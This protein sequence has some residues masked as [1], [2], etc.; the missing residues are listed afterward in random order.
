MKK[1][2]HTKKLPPFITAT[3]ALISLFVIFA[4]TYKIAEIILKN[5]GDFPKIE[6]FLKNIPAEQLNTD[7]KDIKYPNNTVTLSL[8]N[9]VTTFENV[10][11]K[12]RGNLT[13]TQAKKPYQIK[14]PEKTQLF[15]HGAARKWLLLA[16]YL[17]STHLRNDVAFYLEHLLQ[18]ETPISGNFLE[19]YIDNIY[20][21]LYYLT[22]KVEI[23]ENRINIKEPSGIIVELD[24]I[25]TTNTDCLAHSFDNDCF[26]IHDIINP[27]L[28][29]ES[30]SDFI[31]KFNQLEI[32]IAQKDFTTITNL[33]D[34]DSFAKYFLL[35]EF[36]NN[37][38][39]YESSFFLSMDGASDL[40]HAGPGWDFDL[41]LGNKIWSI[42]GID[43]EVFLSPNNDL[44]FKSLSLYNSDSTADIKQPK[45]VSSLLYNL[46]EVPEFKTRVKEIY[47]STLSSKKDELLNY[48]KSQA[49]Y[50]RPAAIRDQERWKLKTDW[51]EEVNYL[52]D[53][54][55][56]R[57]NHFEETYN[58]NPTESNF[59]SAP[60][61]D[62][63]PK[64]PQPSEE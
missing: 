9:K 49:D 13:W 1:K 24:N 8:D 25:H 62:P 46:L 41:S 20:Y 10:E 39:G 2:K 28:S 23:E 34:V 26:V 16:N 31:E 17:D 11:I 21:G 45:H 35:N 55:T 36:T 33:I 56:K 29:T 4:T 43:D 58:K 60:D 61:L 27:D 19:L 51:D 32:A 50:I 47:T 44:S 48:I 38:D 57:Y 53:W 40:I 5:H 22:E 64:S 42:D 59:D 37:P 7:S 3:L 14:L 63:T 15:N 30:I 18:S 6:I 54:I 12:G 52:L